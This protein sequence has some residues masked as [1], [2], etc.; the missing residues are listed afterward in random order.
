MGNSIVPGCGDI[1]LDQV[2]AGP[3][4][5]PPRRAATGQRQP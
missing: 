1:D 3:A 4:G 2:P 5:T